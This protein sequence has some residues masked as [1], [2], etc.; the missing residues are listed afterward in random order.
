MDDRIG[1]YIDAAK[2]LK[3]G[4]YQVDLPVTPL[5]EVGQLGQALKELAVSLER[6]Y[7]E[8]HTLNQ[9]TV[10]INSGILLDQI[11]EE[12]YRDFRNLIPYNRIGFSLLDED[13]KILRARWAR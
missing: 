6:R 3:Q 10:K 5:D 12:V 11:L 13:G 4:N 8:I 9:I 1:K 7:Q 2:Q